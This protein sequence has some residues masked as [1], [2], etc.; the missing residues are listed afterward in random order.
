MIVA[1]RGASFDAPENTMSAFN[2]AWKQQADGIEGDFLRYS[3][4]A[5]RLHP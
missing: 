5:D 3:R 2:L 4:S 1:H